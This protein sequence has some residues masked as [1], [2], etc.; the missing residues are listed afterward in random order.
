MLLVAALPLPH[1]T[2]EPVANPAPTPTLP[3]NATGLHVALLRRLRVFA[4]AMLRMLLTRRSTVCSQHCSAASAMALPTL[5]LRERA[6]RD[7]VEVYA[8]S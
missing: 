3:N 8:L 2:P 7:G 1:T 4:L 5:A 6:L